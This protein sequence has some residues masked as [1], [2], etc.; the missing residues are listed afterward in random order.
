MRFDDQ[1]NFLSHYTDEPRRAFSRFR[2]V[3]IAVVGAG[4]CARAMVQAL[5]DNGAS[6]V[7]LVVPQADGDA[8]EDLPEQVEVTHGDPRTD[9]E[10]LQGAEVLV[11]TP[12]AASSDLLLHGVDEEPGRLVLPVWAFGDELIAGPVNWTGM[13]EGAPHWADAAQS[14]TTHDTDGAASLFWSRA[15]AGMP[16]GRAS[17]WAPALERMIAVIAA[18]EVF[19]AVTGAMEPETGGSILVLDCL[20]GETRRHR[21]LPS[22]VLRPAPQDGGRLTEM[23]RIAGE[24]L[25][26]PEQPAERAS[27][28][29]LEAYDELVGER[30]RPISGF[31]DEDF[32]QLP[33]KVSAARLVAGPAQPVMVGGADLWNVAG[34]RLDA[35]RRALV[36]HLEHWAPVRDSGHGHTIVD[37]LGNRLRYD[38]D[39][40]GPT[41][42]AV[43][44]GTGRRVAVRSAATAT[45]SPANGAGTY[46]RS[47]GG[48]GVGRHAREAV[49][50]ALASAAV[51][52]ALRAATTGGAGVRIVDWEHEERTVFLSACAHDLK[53]APELV[54][55]GTWL[56]HSVVVARAAGVQDGLWE[57]AAGPTRGEAIVAAMTGLIGALQRDDDTQTWTGL[58]HPGLVGASIAVTDQERMP[59]TNARIL[60][61]DVTSP[62]LEAVGLVACKVLV[63]DTREDAD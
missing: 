46:I 57:A 50:E 7:R 55:L 9:H 39:P 14:L 13:G 35:V 38:A 12:C 48:T 62:E 47:C 34:A 23:A 49:A 61:C 37:S 30:T 36:L 54:D 11:L 41:V 53:S 52:M 42:P 27:A 1:I 51:D 18:F 26:R 20:T 33:V 56:G 3:S 21:V 24:L 6:K 43:D 16:T 63:D 40:S 45:L 2:S 29:E 58:S 22:R 15:W 10:A 8:P 32:E 5:T 4:E 31:L 59:D 19:K 60:V 44:V 28:Q 25:G 17:T